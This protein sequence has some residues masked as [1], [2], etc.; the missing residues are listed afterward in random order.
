M[1]LTQDLTAIFGEALN[2]QGVRSKGLVPYEIDFAAN[3]AALELAQNEVIG[4]VDIPA[5]S[6]ISGG[7]IKVITADATVTD[8]D[9]GVTTS[10]AT[11]ATLADGLS[12]ASTGW[13]AFNNVTAGGVYVTADSELVLTNIDTTTCSI[14]KILVLIDIAR[15]GD[16]D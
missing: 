16:V 9:V 8:V 13:I 14:A 1:A 10:S 6:I 4:I 5:G 12:L 11:N 7:F 3:S 2:A 15:F